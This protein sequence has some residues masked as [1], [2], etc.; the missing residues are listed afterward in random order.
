[1]SRALVTSEEGASAEQEFAELFR[2]HYQ[3]MY[4]TAYSVTGSRQDAE[5]AVQAIFLRL[6]QRPLRLKTTT[7]A[8][9][10]RAAVNQAL[11]TLR[12]RKRIDVSEDVEQLLPQVLSPGDPI[13]DTIR[14]AL[15]D[16]MARL[17]PRAVEILILHYEHN[18]SDQEIAGM[19]NATRG[20]IAVTLF[21]A[22]ARLKKLMT[23]SLARR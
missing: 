2:E 19:L 15:Q 7:K 5:D 17:R 1:M 6:M 23:R 10:Y 22:R 16:A 4:R 20:T 11:S 8:Y 18:Y 9:L 14:Q 13:S 12:S 3:F 21:R